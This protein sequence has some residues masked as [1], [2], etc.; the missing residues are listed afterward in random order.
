M[1]LSPKPSGSSHNC[2]DGGGLKG[3]LL[4]AM[5]IEFGG[6]SFCKGQYAHE[7]S[8]LVWIPQMLKKFEQICSHQSLNKAARLGTWLTLIRTSHDLSPFLT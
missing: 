3:A 5:L 2:K 7:E 6:R 1:P 4:S 8:Q